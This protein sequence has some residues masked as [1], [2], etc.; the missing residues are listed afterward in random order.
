[1]S[2]PDIT[3]EIA[4]GLR[5]AADQI[6][7]VFKGSA[8][9]NAFFT[10]PTIPFPI[11]EH[12]RRRDLAGLSFGAL[13]L[14][15]NL[16]AVSI[17]SS[18]L[19]ASIAFAPALLHTK[20]YRLYSI[21]LNPEKVLAR[22]EWHRLVTS[23]LIN[24]TFVQLLE[25]ANDLY[26]SGSWLEKRWGWQGLLGAVGAVSSLAPALYGTCLTR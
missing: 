9:S 21:G 13:R 25:N 18:P 24:A 17:F 4:A 11:D 22:G 12:N 1:M 7:D 19:A 3:H 20:E 26:E 8:R 15:Q 5:G 10:G 2:F 6:V 23:Q 16:Q 14:S